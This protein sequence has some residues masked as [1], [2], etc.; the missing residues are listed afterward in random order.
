MNSSASLNFQIFNFPVRVHFSF[1]LVAIILGINAGNIIKIVLWVLIV[2][3]SVLLHEL[4]HAVA[5]EYY[6]R[7]PRIELYSMGGLTVS[8]RYSLLSYPKEILIGFAGSLAGFLL[9]GLLFAIASFTG[10]IDNEYLHFIIE[11]L[12]WV[13]IGWGVINLIPILPLDGGSI[14]KNAYHWLRNPYD[15]R[16][17]LIISIV[18][19]VLAIIVVLVLMGR[20]GIYLALLAG[21]LTYNNYLA[22]RQGYWTDNLI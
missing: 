21:W 17:P 16:T 4:G 12:L 1:F 6:G 3:F 15:D 8:T 5:A 14:M 2:F 22:L 10:A 20:G 13:N 9:G 11:Q 18:F 19:G 7:S